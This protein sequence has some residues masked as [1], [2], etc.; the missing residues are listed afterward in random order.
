MHL[1]QAL[2]RTLRLLADDQKHDC[3]LEVSLSDQRIVQT[4]N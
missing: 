2:R 1:Q 3:R 4:N